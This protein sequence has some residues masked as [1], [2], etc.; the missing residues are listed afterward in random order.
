[1]RLH[2]RSPA[3]LAAWIGILAPA[4][5][6]AQNDVVFATEEN[7]NGTLRP[8]S[9]QVWETLMGTQAPQFAN[10]ALGQQF[11]HST[12]KPI[13]RYIPGTNVVRLF[14]S[15]AV[16]NG[17]GI[18]EYTP[19]GA[20]TG[21][22]VRL[23]SVVPPSSVAGPIAVND[24]LT[25]LYVGAGTGG[26]AGTIH[27][28]DISG[29]QTGVTSQT[30]G[31]PLRSIPLPQSVTV[32][33]INPQGTRILGLDGGSSKDLVDLDLATGVASVVSTGSNHVFGS[34][35]I[36][37]K[38]GCFAY[39][40]SGQ[41]NSS[42]NVDPATR[43][44]G[45][46]DICSS[47]PGTITNYISITGAKT[48]SGTGIDNLTPADLDFDPLGDRAYFSTWPAGLYG[49]SYILVLDNVSSG[50]ANPHLTPTGFAHYS[51]SVVV[52]P[53]NRRLYMTWFSNPSI[54]FSAFDIDPTTGELDTSTAIVSTMAG[55]PTAPILGVATPPGTLLKAKA[56]VTNAPTDVTPVVTINSTANSVTE[57]VAV[58]ATVSISTT[59]P[60]GTGL[61]TDPRYLFNGWVKDPTQCGDPSAN[62]SLS[63][64]GLPA[65]F[66]VP[67]TYCACF[68]KQWYVGVNITGS[69]RATLNGI[70]VANGSGIWVAEGATVTGNAIPQAN[71]QVDSISG[72]VVADAAGKTIDIQCT[73]VP[74]VCA[75]QSSLASLVGWWSFEDTTTISSDRRGA[76]N[77][78]APVTGSTVVRAT[79]YVGQAL[80]L[81]TGGGPAQITADHA[82]ELDMTTNDFSVDAWIKYPQNSGPRSIVDK[83]GGATNGGGYSVFLSNGLLALSMTQAG[84]PTTAAAWTTTGSRVDDDQWHHVAV[85]VRRNQPAPEFYIDGVLRPS[86]QTF[87]TGMIT[88]SISSPAPLRVGGFNASTSLTDGLIDELEIFNAAITE[89]DI[90]EIIA[91]KN[92]GKCARDDKGCVAPPDGMVSWYKFEELPPVALFADSTTVNVG[93]KLNGTLT[94]AAAKVAQGVFLTAE[95]T[96]HLQALNVTEHNFG[97]GDFSFDFWIRPQVNPVARNILDKSAYSGLAFTAMQG[98]KASLQPNGALSF[99]MG[100]GGARRLW[101]GTKNLADNQ[102]HHVTVS[103]SRT[104]SVNFYIDGA[105]D[106]LTANPAMLTTGSV[107]SNVLLTVG[108]DNFPIRLSGVNPPTAFWIDELEFFNRALTKA[109]ADSIYLAD[110]K[111]KCTPVPV[112]VC[113]PKTSWQPGLVA[114]YGFEAAGSTFVGDLSLTGNN[115][116]VSSGA[117]QTGGQVGDMLSV[118]TRY[119][120]APSSNSLN[121]A[122][123]PFSADLWMRWSDRAANPT[124]AVLISKS[125]A[126]T[127]WWFGL[128]QGTPA[129]STGSARLTLVV[130]DT[131]GAR[132]WSTACQ[133]LASAS[134]RMVGF[135]YAPGPIGLN[136][137]VVSFFID[138]LPVAPSSFTGSAAAP[139]VNS[140]SPLRVGSASWTT[141][142]SLPFTGDVDEVEIFN[143]AKPDSFF[144]QVFDAATVG[145]CEKPA[146]LPP[147]ANY[148]VTVVYQ[149]CTPGTSFTSNPA[150]VGNTISVPVGGNV[151]F[152]FTGGTIGTVTASPGGPLTLVGN[153]AQLTN[154]QGN[155]TITVTCALPPVCYPINMNGMVAWYPLDETGTA[156]GVTHADIAGTNDTLARIGGVGPAPGVVAGGQNFFNGGFANVASPSPELD[157]GIGDFSVDAWVSPLAGSSGGFVASKLGLGAGWY[158]ALVKPTAGPNLEL[159]LGVSGSGAN[160]RWQTQNANIPTGSFTHI[161]VVAR[162]G[163]APAFYING[164]LFTGTITSSGP[165][166]IPGVNVNNASSF[167]LGGGF[168]GAVPYQ[169]ILDEVELFNRV[170]TAAEVNGIYIARGNGKCKPACLANLPTGLRLW[171]GF[172][173][174]STGAATAT[175]NLAAAYVSVPNWT[176]GSQGSPSPVIVANGKHGQA[177]QLTN[178]GSYME[179]LSIAAGNPVSASSPHTID[180]WIRYARPAAGTTPARPL[181]EKM[182]INTTTGFYKGYALYMQNG[183][184]RYVSSDQ[185]N[186]GVLNWDINLSAPAL[187]DDQWHFIAVVAEPGKVPRFFIDGTS[188]GAISS[189]TLPAFSPVNKRKLRLGYLPGGPYSTNGIIDEFEFFSSALTDAEL[190]SIRNA[191]LGKCKRA[192][193][194]P[195]GSACLTGGVVIGGTGTY[196]FTGN[197]LDGSIEVKNEGPV[198][199]FSVEIHD[200][201]GPDGYVLET[202]L[203]IRV[204]D[205]PAGASRRVTFRL[206]RTEGAGPASSPVSI[207]VAG[208]ARAGNADSEFGFTASLS[209]GGPSTVNVTIATTP[210]NAGLQFQAGTA[211]ALATYTNSVTLPWNAGAT[212]ELR[213]TSPQLVNGRQ[214]TFQFWVPSTNPQPAQSVTATAGSTSYNVVFALSGYQVTLN[215]S[216]GCLLNTTP[217]QGNPWIVPTGGTLTINSVTAP[218]GSQLNS[219]SIGTQTYTSFPVSVTVTEPIVINANCGAAQN[220]T[221]TVATNPQGLDARIG[222]TGAY[223]PA[224]L[225]RQVPPGQTQTVSVTDNQV[226]NGTGYRF[227][228][229]STG[230]ST[231]TTNV[232]PNSNFTAT[233]N[234]QTACHVLTFNAQPANGGTVAASPA[235]GVGGFPAN[236]Y[237]PGTSVTLTASASTGFALQNWTGAGGTSNTTTVTVNAPL[238]VTANFNAAQ[239]PVIEFTVSSRTNGN[240]SMN[241]RN[242]GGSAARN[243]RI[244]AISNITANGA[245]FVYTGFPALQVPFIVPGAVSLGVGGN[246]GFNLLFSATSGSAATAF[247]FLITAQADNLPSFTQVVNVAAGVTAGN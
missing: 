100:V 12:R 38:L 28:Y 34:I 67:D 1:M 166:N 235:T 239:P 86:T 133:A 237:A 233:A 158:V 51:Y 240:L 186:S 49:S 144:K 122:S 92:L 89:T 33:T 128:T 138:G 154:V 215:N 4:A 87:G 137:S 58:G 187:D 8:D 190:D 207:D 223:A 59:S 188:Y 90:Q 108:R 134:W 60:Q 204:G 42:G 94:H 110:A 7:K 120:E 234:F 117:T 191:G 72:P 243:L 203:P 113:V 11:L 21:T 79:G 73:T 109:E 48:A 123:A 70:P 56:V 111:G 176:A 13:A 23:A 196:T 76:N 220:V 236:C 199:A 159:E 147:P 129:C 114:W 214:Y 83:F 160:D 41:L 156:A 173:D 140:T 18:L 184:L 208:T 155:T 115:A 64:I 45:V 224:P 185:T 225:T 244:T 10:G 152:T 9:M 124:D 74:A 121:F 125:S 180:L 132:Q 15:S 212:Y 164:A 238:T 197:L 25:R 143:V 69:C 232:Q 189:Q 151:S 6:F 174:I 201:G 106:A 57:S 24:S 171:Y 218:Q 145:K 136:L 119:L 157:F 219:F 127:G 101:T 2:R 206:R 32:L 103:V 50:G 170:L 205:I 162:R 96:G 97:T 241:A 213:T 71:A 30:V 149:N 35:K 93:L 193:T 192:V 209:S 194:C 80:R 167:R 153:A 228:N 14:V 242:T 85:V 105:T 142:I 19:D 181:V 78:L 62:P 82:P 36:E 222:T 245:T 37:T 178:S 229:W 116:T 88:A 168:G 52:S 221:L 63:I 150:A 29:L 230:G 95:D 3:L 169:G 126:T 91:A 183:R 211:T 177:V 227:T 130:R 148:T 44:I 84:S 55:P 200:I 81:G 16:F 99:E 46:I 202:Q 107:N 40:P 54:Y 43:Q 139:N 210:A 27:E 163:A 135:R 247:S 172:D 104:A 5:A 102:W 61:T 65:A 198:D 17:V 182:H 112:P 161:A 231:P 20:G 31:P 53:V 226:R 179:S 175:A 118:G 47:N 131:S 246:T 26:Y 22:F 195:A 216:G 75:T 39:F 68:E 98:Y 217:A 66:P 146:P 77:H 141:G 165:A